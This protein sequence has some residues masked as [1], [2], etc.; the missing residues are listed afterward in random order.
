[1][2]VQAFKSD[3]LSH[4]TPSQIPY[5]MA[6][7]ALASRRG[8]LPSAATTRLAAAEAAACFS[9]SRCRA[10][11]RCR[12]M[13]A[14]CACSKRRRRLFSAVYPGLAKI[15]QCAQGMP[16]ALGGLPRW[17]R[18]ALPGQRWPPPAQPA[19][20]AALPVSP[21]HAPPPAHDGLPVELPALAEMHAFKFQEHG[22]RRALLVH[23]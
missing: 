23:A 18:C 12:P 15:G 19:S 17:P 16:V 4:A 14:S 13:S 5:R 11:S 7:H 10:A 1:M 2:L 8:A 21:P 20:L 3:R 6:G 22:K 9:A